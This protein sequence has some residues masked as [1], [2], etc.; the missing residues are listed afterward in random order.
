MRGGGFVCGAP[1]ELSD[2]RVPPGISIGGRT[3][4]CT[5]KISIGGKTSSALMNCL[6]L[7]QIL[8]EF[9][10]ESTNEEEQ[11]KANE[12]TQAN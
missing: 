11:T 8:C 9:V 12:L 7:L 5:S 2:V 10:G 3:R 4:C 6:I 1:S